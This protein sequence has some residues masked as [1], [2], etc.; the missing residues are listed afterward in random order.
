MLSK[1]TFCSKESEKLFGN[2]THNIGNLCIECYLKLHGCCGVCNQSFLPV[3]L[4]FD[5]TYNIRARF[6][7]TGERNFIVCDSCFVEIRR[8]FPH[9]FV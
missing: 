7:G 1:C 8:E 5:T 4:Q 3:E 6:I 9:L 2:I